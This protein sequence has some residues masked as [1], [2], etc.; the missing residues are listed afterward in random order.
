MGPLLCFCDTQIIIHIHTQGPKFEI[1]ITNTETVIGRT[2]STSVCNYR[3]TVHLGNRPQQSRKK[4][5]F[6]I[7][8]YRGQ[9]C[10]TELHWSLSG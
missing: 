6:G 10:R 9:Q 5:K 8:N 4:R 2:C 1:A 3:P 7:N